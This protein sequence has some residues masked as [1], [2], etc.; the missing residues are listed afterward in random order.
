MTAHSALPWPAPVW[1]RRR[2]GQ[3][4][5]PVTSSGPLE[6]PH[7]VAAPAWSALPLLVGHVPLS[8]A[9]TRYS[10]HPS[11]YAQKAALTT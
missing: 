9:L 2:V 11:T 7:D 6:V 5:G 10:F 4:P 1:A 3:S 8:V